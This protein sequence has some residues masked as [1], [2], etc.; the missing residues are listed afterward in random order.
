AVAAEE[1]R[2]EEQ[3][4]ADSLARAALEEAPA[5]SAE[6]QPAQK[7]NDGFFD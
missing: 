2:A 5:E 6:E 3:Q 1:R 4:L 7:D